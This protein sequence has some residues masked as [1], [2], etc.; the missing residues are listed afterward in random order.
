[1]RL[2]Y[3]VHDVNDAAVVRRVTT[4]DEGGVTTVV[5][6]FRRRDHIPAKVGNAAVT[7]LGRTDD[8]RL[9]ERVLTV[10]RHW[11]FPGR[12]RRVTRDA[13]AIVAR[14]LEMLVLA[15]RVRR[16]GQRLVYECLD[17]HR[18][19]LGDSPAC[20][21]LQE[22][23]RRLLRRIDLLIV[24]SPSF[25]S[26]YFVARRGYSGRALLVENKVPVLDS[27]P[28][29]PAPV[30]PGPP[31]VIGWFGML[32]CKKSLAQLSRIAASAEGRIEVVIAGRPSPNEF[33]DFEAQ[34]AAPPHLRYLG[35]YQPKDLARLYAAVHFVWAIDYFEEGLNSSWL[36]PN[37]LYEG[38][39]NGAVPLA[40]RDVETG[41]WLE[42]A[43]VG[44]LL[45]DPEAELP[46]LISAMTEQSYALITRAVRALPANRVLMS[47]TECDAM[48]RAIMG[49]P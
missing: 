10:L 5:G 20:R 6:G 14:N 11:L 31:W 34:V 29:A 35:P 26:E 48:I 33:E 40:L 18:L 23:E 4:F 24:S 44:L 15:R 22:I 12:L 21:L 36:L 25:L 42:R 19:L 30:Q 9:K 38:L 32:R 27:F 1:L 49:S 17:I 28:P 46:E 8:G 43:G 7:D 16:K 3:L 41:S 37:R 47:R 39:A 13:D 2:A 45:A